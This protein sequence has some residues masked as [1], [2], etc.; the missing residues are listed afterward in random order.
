LQSCKQLP[1]SGGAVIGV[2]R[3]AS[4]ELQRLAARIISGVD[5]GDGASITTLKEAIGEQRID[6]L[7]NNAGIL[8][9]EDLGELDYDEMT[10]QVRVNTVGQLWVASGRF[11]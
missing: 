6:V 3:S 4:D 8:R 11:S 7:I 5:V 1:E 10:E 9:R 2:C